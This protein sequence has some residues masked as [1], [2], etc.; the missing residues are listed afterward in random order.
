[1][2]LYSVHCFWIV[3]SW[4][5]LTAAEAKEIRFVDKGRAQSVSYDGRAWKQ[6][7]D[8]LEQAGEGTIAFASLGLGAGDAAWD[9]MGSSFYGDDGYTS[10]TDTNDSPAAGFRIRV[11]KP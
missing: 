7:A 1:M 9:T 5:A 8:C 3:V 2:R 4:A 11:W 10:K 6:S